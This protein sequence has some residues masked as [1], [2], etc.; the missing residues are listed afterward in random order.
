MRRPGLHSPPVATA[1]RKSLDTLHVAGDFRLIAATVMPDHIHVLGTLG[2]RLALKSVIAKFK[3][4]ARS[5]L[6]AEHLV[7]QPNFY[8]HR[9]RHDDPKEAF[10]RYI[11]LNPYRARLIPF[12]AT[13]PHWWRWG[14]LRFDFESIFAQTGRIPAPWLD[15]PGPAGAADL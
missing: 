5:T 4:L 13:W 2:H 12:D 11:F 15:E 1:I 14:D 7:F 8:D 10:A 6:A 9:L 3:T